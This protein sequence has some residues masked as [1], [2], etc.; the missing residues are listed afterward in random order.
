MPVRSVIGRLRA[1]GTPPRIL[2][3]DVARGLAVLGM[4]G[5][6]IGVTVAWN[7]FEPATW[8]DVVH[9]RSSIL[10]ALLAGVS[11]AI[12]SGGF[13]PVAGER[14]LH[15]RSRILVR[16]GLIFAIGG[17]LEALGTRIA[18]I[19]PVYAVLF[20]VAIPF[21]RWRPRS[22]FLLAGVLAVVSPV[23]HVFLAPLPDTVL[24]R[25][26][27]FPNLV[28]WG[29]YPG[30]IWIVFVLVGLGIGRLDLRSPRVQGI[31]LGAG[32]LLAAVAYGAG[33]LAWAAIG[34]TLGD[35]GTRSSLP[36]YASQ[37]Q[38]GELFTTTA[39]SGS[40]FEV[41][42]STGFALAVLGLCLLI[43]G[44]LRWVLYPV[45]AVGA[46]ALTAYTAHVVVLAALGDDAFEQQD[47][48]LYLVFVVAALLGCA[49]WTLLFGRG[50]LERLLTTTSRRVADLA[51]RPKLDPEPQGDS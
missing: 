9:G 51:L 21:L 3:I 37:V 22:L 5:A 50:P 16:A 28:L 49:A 45:A 31:I 42:G 29:A 39:H 48:T 7:W 8:L 36:D 33:D 20:V 23:I 25:E 18:V 13:E 47:N 30:I 44:R 14:L 35:P 10:F 41:V 27:A 6:H 19:L 34:R 24:T 32:A 12:I 38:F 4:F 1:Y 40:T 43:S 46:M 17:V 2:G 11:I 26:G 15:A